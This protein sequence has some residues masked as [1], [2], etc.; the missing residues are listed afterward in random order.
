VR[1][2]HIAL[3]TRDVPALARFYVALLG[4]DVVRRDATRGSVWLD[5]EGT[6][7][8]IELAE[9]AEPPVAAGT[10]ELVAFAVDDK[11]T[12]RRRLLEADVAIED[13]TPYTL[14]FRDPDGRRVGVSSFV[15]S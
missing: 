10:R 5:A 9:T 11:E 6:L 7:L 4:F 12:W 14:Y 2:H 1:I 13:E 3:R 15:R 8:M